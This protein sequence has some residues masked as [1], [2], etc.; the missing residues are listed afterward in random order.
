MGLFY[1][2]LSENVKMLG[3]EAGGKGIETGE[4]AARL[5][6]A[7]SVYFRGVRVISCR[8]MTEMS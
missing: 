5:Q 2:F 1:E 4:H 3:V 7:L 6:V 8:T